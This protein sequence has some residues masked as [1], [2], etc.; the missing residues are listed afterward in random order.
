MAG[1]VKKPHKSGKYRGWFANWQGNQEFFT[2]TTSPQETRAMA[3]KFEDDHRQIRLGYRPPKKTSDTPRTFAEVVKEYIS[4]GTSQGGHGGRKWSPVHVKMRTR[5]LTEFWPKH[6]KTMLAEVALQK[7]E[8]GARVLQDKKLSGKTIQSH[9]ESIKA[10]CI[11][12]TERGYFEKDPLAGLVPFDTSPRTHRRALTE[13]EISKLLDASPM[14]RRMVYEVALCTGYRKAELAALKLKDLDVSTCTLSLSAEHC[15]G[16]KDSRQPIP[17]SLALKLQAAFEG[18]PGETPLLDVN[19]HIDRLFI[20]DRTAAEIL[21]TA[22]GGVAVFHSLRHTYCSMIIE[23]GAT[24]K[25]AQTLLRHMDPKLTMNVYA[26]A[27]AH[28]LAATAEAI[29]LKVIS[30]EKY[31]TSM[32]RLAVGAEAVDVKACDNMAL[33]CVENGN[34]AGFE[35]LHPL[36]FS[37]KK[38]A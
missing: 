19:F 11:W 29:G 24:C 9:L 33:A 26:H 4:W 12:C 16:R 37:S 34:G 14:N 22:P 25:E 6:L 23:S 17:Q 5:H 2:G 27:G 32:Q 18:K 8:V 35:P 36:L 13:T 15:K 38:L 1:I 21:P 3:K 20:R 10:F 31:A 30:G 7:V 28:R